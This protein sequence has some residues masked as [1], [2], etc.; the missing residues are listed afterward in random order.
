MYSGYNIRFIIYTYSETSEK[1]SLVNLI[2][3]YEHREYP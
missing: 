2:H 3:P 1:C